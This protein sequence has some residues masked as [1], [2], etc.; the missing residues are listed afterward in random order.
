MFLSLRNHPIGQNQIDF[1][2][3]AVVWLLL[4]GSNYA[5]SSS[6]YNNN[7]AWNINYNGNVNNNNKNNNQFY[8]VPI[9]NLI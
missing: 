3:V 8:V 1:L 4:G 5:W 6:E 7:N 2:K 9:Q